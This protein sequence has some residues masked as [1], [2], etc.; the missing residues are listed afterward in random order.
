MQLEPHRD[1]TAEPLDDAN[2]T[3]CAA[4]D[5]HEVDQPDDAAGGPKI[6]LEDQR[7]AAIPAL[8]R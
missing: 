2:H 8:D 4:A 3:G 5:R 6:G 1:F 7:V